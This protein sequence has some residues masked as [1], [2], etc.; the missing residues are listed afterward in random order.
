MGQFTQLKAA[1]GQSIP[2]YVAT[3]S[4]KPRGG[5]VVIQEIFGVNAG[6]RA[7]ADDYARKGYI[8][9]CP[10]LF[11]RVEPGLELTDRT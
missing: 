8:A 10:D 11:W 7:I 9:V 6:I 2:A 3:P 4:G 5:I 1:D